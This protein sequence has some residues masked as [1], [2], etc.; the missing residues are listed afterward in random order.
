MSGR[1]FEVLYDKDF[2]KDVRRIPGECQQKLSGLLEILQ[3]DPFDPRLHAKPLAAPLQGLFSFRIT[4]DWRVGF[5]FKT[6]ETIQLLAAD[7]RDKI[8][9]RLRRKL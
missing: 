2:L 4:R 1:R 3:N 8:Y 9:Q 6:A 7:G 5:K